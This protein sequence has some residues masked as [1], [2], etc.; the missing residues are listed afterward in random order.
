VRVGSTEKLVLIF[1]GG[2]DTKQDD[3]PYVEDTVGRGIYMVDA[4]TGALIWR[5]GPDGGANLR[6]TEMR[7]SVPSDIRVID[8]TGDGFADRMYA[9]DLGGRIWRFD[10]FNGK[11]AVGYG[12][13]GD[14]LVEGG[15]VASLGNVEE[16]SPR[17]E[18]NT[19]RFFYS[20]DPALITKPGPN[21]INIAIG[22]GHREMPANDLTTQ[23]WFFS[24]R[25]YNVFTQ[26]LS[27]WYKDDCSGA[28]T[29]CFQT[30]H[31][32]DLTDLTDVVG[33]DATAAVPVA[34]PGGVAG[35]RILLEEPGEKVL[36][37]ARTFQDSVF[38]TS[39]SPTEPEDDNL[40]ADTCGIKFG[41]NKL[42]VV[43]A[44]DARPVYPYDAAVGESAEDRSKTL[45]QG[46]IAPEVVF[47]FPTPPPDASG[48]AVPAVPPVCLVG[49]ENCGFGMTNP[50]VR[51]YWRQRGAN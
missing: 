3:Q 41:L 20:P 34:I 32:E 12:T 24:V 13:E 5:A 1:G 21:F 16:A 15:M 2:Y 6:L 33:V 19:L 43:N 30:V 9:A 36:A 45:A 37:E 38:F 17:T 40:T 49:L 8:L 18:S 47:V 31:E 25:D 23:N 4:L 39:Y 7:H 14:R 48:G 28:V 44:V 29:P 26:L 42:Y 51:T 22:S 27:S 50:P 11:T 46:S 35:W 10:I